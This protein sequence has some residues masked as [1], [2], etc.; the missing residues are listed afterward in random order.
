MG[1]LVSAGANGSLVSSVTAI[2]TGTTTEGAIRLFHSDGTT[3]RLLKELPVAAVTPSATVPAWA[4]EI[5]LRDAHGDPFPLPANHSLKVATERGET[6]N[7][8]ARGAHF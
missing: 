4:G 7:V 5:D 8:F 6:F 1:D 2:A 3:T